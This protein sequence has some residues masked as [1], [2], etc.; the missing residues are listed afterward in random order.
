MLTLITGHVQSGKTTKLITMCEVFESQGKR[1]FGLVSPGIFDSLGRKTG[2]NSELLPTHET[3]KVGTKT[4]VGWNFDGSSIAKVNAHFAHLNYVPDVFV[5]DEIG[6]LELNKNAG[7]SV[8]LSLLKVGP[9][10]CGDHA[11]VVVRHKLK[12]VLLE[13]IERAWDEVEILEVCSK[14]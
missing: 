8:A 1:V 12:D 10:V 7:F 5:V 11:I 14:P 2:V 6:P 13:Q 9:S 4:S 3:F